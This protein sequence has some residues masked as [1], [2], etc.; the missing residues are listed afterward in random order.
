[1]DEHDST[2]CIIVQERLLTEPGEQSRT[3]RCC[4]HVH[5]RIRSF[6]PAQAMRHGQQMHIM[7]PQDRDSLLSEFPHEP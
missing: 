5:K 4:E 1:M 6:Q 7:I 2:C 3:I